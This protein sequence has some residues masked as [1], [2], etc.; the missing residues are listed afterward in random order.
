MD[1]YGESIYGTQGGPYINGQWGGATIV[2]DAL[3]LHIFHW[4]EGALTLP[5]LPRKVLSCV[6]LGGETVTCTQSADRLVLELDGEK[7]T[8]LHSVV[9]L[10]LAPGE[11]IPV[12]AVESDGEENAL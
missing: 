4:Q 5:A 3:Y 12:I 11:P 8:D 7:A 6:E 1:T 9:K 10:T 2:G